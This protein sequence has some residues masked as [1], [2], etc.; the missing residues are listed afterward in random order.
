MN[1]KQY[2]TIST[3]MNAEL[4]AVF[5]KFG[6]DVRQLRAGI[7]PKIGIVKLS[8]ELGDTNQKDES[9]ATVSPDALYYLEHVKMM[10]EFTKLKADWLNKECRMGGENYRLVGMK[11]KGKNCMLILRLRDNSM[12]VTSEEQVVLFFGRAGIHPAENVGSTVDQGRNARPLGE[13]LG[14]RR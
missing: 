6:F 1:L 8:I 13:L 9:G 12:R 5:A 3:Q 7:D 4:T 14:D 11:R 10:G 2:R